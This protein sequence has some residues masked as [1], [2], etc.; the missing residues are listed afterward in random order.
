MR[1][2]E[3]ILVFQCCYLQIWNFAAKLLK[4]VPGNGILLSL[5]VS[6]DDHVFTYLDFL[7]KSRKEERLKVADNV[8]LLKVLLALF[9]VNLSNILR[10]LES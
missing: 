5:I 1:S 2:V 7:H 3:E 4:S 6:S 9:N 8:R 10:I